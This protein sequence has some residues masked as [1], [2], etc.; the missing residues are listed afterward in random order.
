MNKWTK[1]GQNGL[2][3]T[4]WIELDQSGPNRTK[5]DQNRP[6]GPKY[7]NNVAQ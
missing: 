7:S 6:N 3:W 5:V 1:V 4:R 2:K